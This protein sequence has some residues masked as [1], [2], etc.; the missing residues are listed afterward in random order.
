MWL[1]GIQGGLYEAELTFYSLKTHPWRNK[2]PV[3]METLKV[4]E[5]WINQNTVNPFYELPKESSVK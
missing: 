3:A 1:S 4:D 5:R 2:Y